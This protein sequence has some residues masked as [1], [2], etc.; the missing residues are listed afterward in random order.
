MEQIA[1]VLSENNWMPLAVIYVNI[2]E[3]Q[4]GFCMNPIV[5][6]EITRAIIRECGELEPTEH[7]IIKK[8]QLFTL[9]SKP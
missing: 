4:P 3:T 2:K 9:N 8:V 1:L 7:T 6:E 5:P